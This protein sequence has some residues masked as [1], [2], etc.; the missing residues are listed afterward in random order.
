MMAKV[1]SQIFGTKHGREMKRIQPIVDRVNSFATA[2]SGLSDE[3]LKKKTIEFKERYKKGET[4]EQLLPEAFAVCREASSRALGMRHY[5]VQ[6]IGGYVLHRGSIAE[7]RTG[8]GKTLVATLPVYLNA[9]TGKGVHVVTVNDYLARRDAEWMGKLYGWLGLTTGIIVHGLTD[10]ERK[11]AYGCDITYAT[12]NELG[13]DYLRDNMKFEIEDY[14]QRPH[15]YAIVDECDSILID[16]A[17]TPLIIS[18]PA[19][20]STDKYLTV[21]K[22][23]PHL[24]RDVHFTMEEKSKT[25]SLTEEGNHEVER[26]LGVGNVYDPENIELLHH[27]YQGLKAHHL[28]RLDV[29][30]MINNGEIVIVDEFTGRL[31]PGRRWSD[32]L[33]QAIEAKEGV[34]VKNENQTL[35]T[36]TFQN[37]FKMYEKLSGMTGT[38]DTEAVEFKKIY[39]LDVSVIPT[40]RPIS[41]VD[42]DDVVYKNENAKFKAIVADI[43]E[44]TA[45]G[46]PI[47]VGTASIEKSEL[48]SAFL[49]RE[50]IRHDVLNAKAHEREAEI[51]AQAGR[52]GAVTI[53]TNMAG[54]GTD[55]VLGGNAEIMAKRSVNPEENPEEYKSIYEKFKQKF[56][57]EK[58]EVVAAG[59]LYIIGTERHESRRIDNQLRGRSGRQGDPGESKFYLSLE[60]NLMRIFNGERI[61]K[62]MGM[63]N[64]PEDEPITA[65]MVTNAI[66]GAQ[67]KVEGHNFDMR[68][69]LL[70]YDNV[71]NMQRNAIYGMRKRALDGIEIERTI[72]DMLGDVTSHLLDLHVPENSKAGNWSLDGL[73]NALT[74]QFG[75]KVEFENVLQNSSISAQI[76]A[77]TEAVK[78]SVKTT[79]DRQKASMG[80]YTEQIMKMILLQSIDQ[81]WKEH[82]L[83]IDKL[84]EGIGLRGYSGKDPLI[85]YKKEAFGAFENLNNIIKADVIEKVMRVQIVAQ[86]AENAVES[87]RPQETNLDELE[88]QAPSE[89][90]IGGGSFQAPPKGRPVGSSDPRSSAGGASRQPVHRVTMSRES[91]SESKM[92]RADRRR[93]EKKGKR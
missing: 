60:D 61:Q 89:L 35:A 2:M 18:G 62:I 5:D 3:Q 49:K 53:A 41:R 39:H 80:P 27:L 81:R 38:A 75:F 57:Q 11:A 51:V 6:V 83:V 16:E 29:E 32:G 10:A 31:M 43:K 4:L 82:L 71:M 72:L 84:K 56:D 54:R 90:D 92:N 36:I 50:G 42:Q 17:R 21:N 76:G 28:Y 70:D 22:I 40:N 93:L 1:L 67:R 44:R 87:F 24:K 45:K 65:K 66:E 14:V 63:L 64:I 20:A 13:F 46:Q 73:N 7:M 78:S 59:G 85:E 68:K 9:L 15:H 91:A 48:L 86:Q 47:L 55:I 58:I 37:F 79:Y 19:E 34:E 25:A 52:K 30:Y 74:Q 77:V 88:Y 69:N 23:I 26:L 12:N 33:H 8:E